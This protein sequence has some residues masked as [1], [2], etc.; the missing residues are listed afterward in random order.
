MTLPERDLRI[1]ALRGVAALAVLLF[2]AQNAWYLG[3]GGEIAIEDRLR[4]RDTWLGLASSPLTL[5]FL[6]LN[7]FFVLSGLC[8]HA[9]Y[10]GLRER[11]AGFSY[12]AYLRRRFWRIYPAYAGAIAFSLAWLALAEWIRHE[13]YGASEVS[14]YAAQWFWQTMRYLSFTHTLTVDTFGGY[15]AP[16]YTMAIEAHFYLAYPAVL[17]GFR[18][19]GPERTLAVSIVVSVVCSALALA[20]G[21]PAAKRLVLESFLVR[22]PEWIM[23]CLIAELWFRSRRGEAPRVS[24]P[25]VVS[26]ALVLFVAAL[27]LQVASGVSPNLLWSGALALAIPAYLI[28]RQGAP[29]AWET[30][31]ARA[32]LCSY[33]IYLLHYP[34]LRVAALLLP[35]QPETLALNALLYAIVVAAA[36]LLARGFFAVFERPFLSARAR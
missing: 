26:A 8:I 29:A 5:G 14:A 17:Y 35:P 20:S 31:L 34:I 12:G 22:W 32:G 19:L 13:R 10:L 21:D 25:G 15:N 28:G 18:R 9:W 6:G 30:A 7:L 2:H 23:G 3:V 24:G 33:S 11:G 1:D 16:L 27:A 36:V 4:L